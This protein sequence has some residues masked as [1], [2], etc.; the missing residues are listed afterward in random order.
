[1]HIPHCLH[2][3]EGS[4]D[5]YQATFLYI[6][7]RNQ[8]STKLLVW[9]AFVSKEGWLVL[10][11]DGSEVIR[12]FGR[13]HPRLIFCRHNHTNNKQILQKN[14]ENDVVVFSFTSLLTSSFSDFIV[15]LH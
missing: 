1:M 2:C 4:L 8:T 3:D 7:R 14:A 9:I 15:E 5:K 13:Y 12:F 6:S 11:H 10:G